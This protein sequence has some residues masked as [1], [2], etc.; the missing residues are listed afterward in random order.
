MDSEGFPEGDGGL[1]APQEGYWEQ[2]RRTF[3]GASPSRALRKHPNLILM[4]ASGSSGG[5]AEAALFQPG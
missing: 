1:G 2:E 3:Q 4:R 5:A